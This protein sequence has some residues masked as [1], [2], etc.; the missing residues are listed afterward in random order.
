MPYSFLHPFEKNQIAIYGLGTETERFL[1]E[2][3][4]KYQIIGLLDGFRDSG[5]QFGRPIITMEYATSIPVSLILVIARPGSCNAIAKRIGETCRK[6][7]IHLLDIRGNDL[8]AEKQALFD[9][10]HSAISG[11]SKKDWIQKEQSASVISFDLFDTLV[12]RKTLTQE[13]LLTLVG[14]K[15]QETGFFIPDFVRVRL[16]AEK[17][18]SIGHAPYLTDIYR[19]ILMNFPAFSVS[20][21]K[22]ANLE[23]ETD[24]NNLIPRSD[25]VDLYCKAL[26]DCKQVCIVSDTYYTKD[27]IEEILNRCGIP[28]C[29]G[30]FLSCNYDTGKNNRLF[31]IF[32]YGYRNYEKFLHTG[33]DAVSDIESASKVN[34]AAFKIPG[35]QE[36]FDSLGGMN[37]EANIHT[38][39]DRIKVSLFLSQLFN[40]PF[41]F[42]SEQKGKITVRTS[43]A[44]GYLFAAPLITDFTLWYLKQVSERNIPNSW[45]CA[46][47]GYLLQK[48]IRL[49]DPENKSCYFLTSRIAAIRAG[50]ENK[51]DIAYVDSMKFSGTVEENLKARFGLDAEVIY[52]EIGSSESNQ[53]DSLLNYAEP[54]LESA[55]TY[56]ANFWKYIHTLNLNNGPIAFF[57]FVAKG[58]SQMYAQ[59]LVPDHHMIGYYFLQLEPEFMRDKGLEIHP[60]F[61]NSELKTSSIYNNYYILETIL[62]SPEPSVN[63]FDE[64]GKPVFA[65]ETRR[66][67]DIECILSMQQGVLDY[68]SDYL[69]LVPK[70]QRTINKELDG[71]LLDLIHQ[72]RIEATD[73]LSLKVEDPFFNRWTAM[74]DEL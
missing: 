29:D 56:R 72:V 66:E 54:I 12:M 46:R 50:M 59:K 40:S 21:E 57:D 64:E 47:D 11:C 23:F 44:I 60:F 13:N 16:G 18:L 19:E 14:M 34:I 45:L 3:G 1:T 68:F 49:A 4:N 9:F 15:L 43:Y 31:Q 6:Y 74:T 33:D 48:L 30:I 22:M 69:S 28:K 70:E 53:T 61:T 2:Y 20:P 17:H 67:R 71:N 8:L 26:R 51:N 5:E 58:T 55:K 25:M 52:H 42:E 62:T 38:Y 36:L 35:A 24:L 63:G 65:A 32:R 37:L 7:H 27:Q 10:T 39:S 73:F 41:Q